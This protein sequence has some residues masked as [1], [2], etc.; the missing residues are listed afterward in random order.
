MSELFSA[1]IET[2]KALD[3]LGIDQFR[4]S[5]SEVLGATWDET[6]TGNITQLADRWIDRNVEA[7]PTLGYR[8]EI[9]EDGQPRN[10]GIPNPNYVESPMLTP[11]EANTKYGIS[12][13]GKSHLSWNEPVRERDAKELNGLKRDELLRNDIINRGAGGF[14]QGTAKLGVGLGA[15]LIDPLN[16]LSAF[17]PIVGEANFARLLAT[18]G[19]RVAARAMTGAIEGTVGAAMLEPFVYGLS[20]AEQRDYTMADSMLN[21]AFGGVLGGGLHVGGGAIKDRLFGISKIIDDAPLETKRAMLG[22]AL[23]SVM[24]DRPVRADLALREHLLGGTAN[25]TPL[26]MARLRFDNAMGPFMPDRA[27]VDM[28]GIKTE[29]PHPAPDQSGTALPI[30]T[31][32]ETPLAFTTEKRA[33]NAVDRIERDEGYRPEIVRTGDQFVL[34]RESQI[35]PVYN[36]DGSP[37]T[38]EN[39]RQAE[40]YRDQI[41]KDSNLD[42]MPVS[43][44]GPVRYALVAGATERDLIAARR[45]PEHV[46]LRPSRDVNA[47]MQEEAR[48]I[49]AN[50]EQFE[51][52]VDQWLKDRRNPQP[53]VSPADARI[54]G[55]NELRL[56]RARGETESIRREGGKTERTLIERDLADLDAQIR[57]IDQVGELN[58][59][60]KAA[61]KE[62]DDI[63]IAA[64][65][66]AGQYER[67]AACMRG[68]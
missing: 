64:E 48:T 17:I 1:P 28:G 3:S 29:V 15:S 20:K 66:R 38:F 54:H 31:K 56:E 18:S 10:V 32:K 25:V 39:A 50:R 65:E 16:I 67:I 13:G 27:R 26:D 51:R 12:A 42:V 7:S 14:W 41:L 19:S 44:K 40:R 30:L 37:M 34:R 11:E 35:E 52:D 5:T 24:E 22:D 68:T 47:I 59:E 57:A 60:A 43:D 36:R 9:G 49:Q 63:I 33:Q 53:R 8:V 46:A 4:S 23:T 55:E 58:P 2:N 6:F 62:G 45:A 61:L 21:I